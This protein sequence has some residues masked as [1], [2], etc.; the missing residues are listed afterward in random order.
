[1]ECNQIDGKEQRKH[2]AAMR[3]SILMVYA[4]TPRRTLA[5]IVITIIRKRVLPLVGLTLAAR[6]ATR[7]D[8]CHRPR[9]AWLRRHGVHRL[10][11]AYRREENV[12]G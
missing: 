12:Q 4:L 5:V 7:A 11:R 3:G 2:V 10:D 8:D 9:C 6:L 1:M